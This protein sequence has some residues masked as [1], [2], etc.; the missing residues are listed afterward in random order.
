MWDQQLYYSKSIYLKLYFVEIEIYENQKGLL[1]HSEECFEQH[2]KKKL[3]G[4]F[5]SG[6]DNNFL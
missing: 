2:R 4:I 6:L 3:R 5:G 1:F